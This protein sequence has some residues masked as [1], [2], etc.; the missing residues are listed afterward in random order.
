LRSE[1]SEGRKAEWELLLCPLKRAR[2]CTRSVRL[3]FVHERERFTLAALPNSMT[4]VP[5]QVAKREMGLQ[6]KGGRVNSAECHLSP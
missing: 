4:E 5:A 2:A 3:E 6:A 1:A